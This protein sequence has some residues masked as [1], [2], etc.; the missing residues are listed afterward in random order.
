MVYQIG[1]SVLAGFY[2]MLMMEELLANLLN[3]KEKESSK[4]DEFK[5]LLD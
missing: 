5:P 3:V 1:L 2:L 4:E